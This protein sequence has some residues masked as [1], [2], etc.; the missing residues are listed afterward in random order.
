[1][2]VVDT[3]DAM[4]L[5]KDSSQAV[6]NRLRRAQGQLNGVIR[7]LEDGADCEAVLTQLA[8]VGKAINRAGFHLVTESLRECVMSPDKND[9]D[10]ARLEKV[11]LSLS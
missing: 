6:L 3:L 7:M 11:F 4:E 2:Y 5:R 10:M 1:M 8:A 9:V